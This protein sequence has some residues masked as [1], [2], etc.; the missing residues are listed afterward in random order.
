MRIFFFLLLSI[1]VSASE[2][3]PTSVPGEY[4]V[5]FKT[6]NKSSLSLMANQIKEQTGME[7]KTLIPSMNVSVFK[8]NGEKLNI[9]SFKKMNPNIEIIEP[10]FI[11]SINQVTTTKP[12]DPSL[13][14]LW[15]MLNIGQPDSTG[16]VGVPGMDINATKA[17]SVQTGSADVIVAVIDT[18]VNYKSK[19]LA[20]NMWM[21]QAE[22]NGKKGVDDDNNG[23]VD[24]IYG[25]NFVPGAKNPSDPLDDQGHGSH[26][27]GTIGATGNDKYGIVGVAWKTKIMALKFLGAD[28][29]GSLDAALQAI[30]YAT[31]NGA[32]VLSNSWGGGEYSEILKEAIERTNKAG[33]IFVA[34]AGNNSS[35]NDKE[36]NYPAN[37]DVPNV[38]SVAAIDNKGQLASFSNY[39]KNK[40]H[41]GAP[42]VNIYSTILKGY[43]SWSGTSM[44]T[45]HV[46][47]AAVLVAS[48]YPT[49]TGVQ[50]KETLLN[51]AKPNKALR[52]KVSTAGNLDVYA[53]LMQTKVEPDP[54]DPYNWTSKVEYQL[55]TEHPYKPEQK[56][57]WEINVP[58]ANKIALYFEKMDVEFKYDT[59]KLYDSTGKLV[60]IITGDAGDA[61]SEPITGNYVKVVFETDT[62]VEKY[63]FD[64][65]KINYK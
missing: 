53:A 48:Q 65:T 1:A 31:K 32:K 60:Q 41:I 20:G 63:G 9:A 25:W 42:G 59:I 35:N 17:W 33:A 23:F 3:K 46:S 10:N 19:D 39:G 49:M 58:S 24:D 12:N 11:Y 16:Q 40:V 55:S 50:I 52:N 37:Y 47:G 57:T 27:S 44:A 36:E 2:T 56:S 14:K 51:A 38:L 4:V 26:C 28:G 34:A 13:S 29:S 61:Y 64:I 15:G 62:S 43:D 30:D 54:E 22:K 8:G 21:N 7:V 5:K 45:P 6:S 18:G